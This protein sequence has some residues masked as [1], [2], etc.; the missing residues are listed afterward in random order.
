MLEK[1]L[2][3]ELEKYTLHFSGLTGYLS[4]SVF[5]ISID[6]KNLSSILK[7]I[8]IQNFLFITFLNMCMDMLLTTLY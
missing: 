5:K 6:T 8:L 2:W 3:D 4:G 7:M 1:G